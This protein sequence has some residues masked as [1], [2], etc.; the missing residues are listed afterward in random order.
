MLIYVGREEDDEREESK[1]AG[2][3]MKCDII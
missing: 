3:K 2:A 1:N